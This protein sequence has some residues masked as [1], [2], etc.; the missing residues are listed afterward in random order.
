MNNSSFNNRRS[1]TRVGTIQI[2]TVKIVWN[3]NPSPIIT[4]FVYTNSVQPLKFTKPI[5][6]NSEVYYP[7]AADIN[8]NV[9]YQNQQPEY[10]PTNNQYISQYNNNNNVA[11][12]AQT[13]L[14]IPEY[15]ELPSYNAIDITKK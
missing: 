4:S 12:D 7:Q 2:P 10:Y 1:R 6:K 8:A 11:N 3:L 5:I 13:A 14:T 15:Q 9:Q